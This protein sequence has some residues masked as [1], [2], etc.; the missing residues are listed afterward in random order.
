MSY[1]PLFKHNS[2]KT[3]PKK[4]DH[5]SYFDGLEQKLLS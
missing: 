3:E 1:L 2:L 5:S 4:E